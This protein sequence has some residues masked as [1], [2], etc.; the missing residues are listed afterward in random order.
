MF[1]FKQK[2]KPSTNFEKNQKCE[3]VSRHVC[4]CRATSSQNNLLLTAHLKGQVKALVN[5]LLI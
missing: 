5:R 3:N 1:Q 4:L 2:Y